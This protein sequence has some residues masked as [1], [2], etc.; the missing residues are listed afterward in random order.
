MEICSYPYN[1]FEEVCSRILKFYFT[2]DAEHGMG[3]L[4]LVS[5]IETVKTKL[6]SNDC[7][8]DSYTEQINAITDVD[9]FIGKVDIRLEEPAEGK[10]IDLII[11]CANCVI[12]IE[13][14]ITAGIY[15]PLEKYCSHLKNKYPGKNI[16]KI[17]LSVK[18]IT[19]PSDYKKINDNGFISILYRSLFKNVKSLSGNYLRQMKY[20]YLLY[21]YDFMKTI[22]NKDNIISKQEREFFYNNSDLIDSIVARRDKYNELVLNEQKEQIAI[23]SEIMGADWKTWEGWILNTSLEE[24][25]KRIGIDSNYE[26]TPDSSCGRFCIY[27]TTWCMEAWWPYKKILTETFPD[28]FIDEY[29]GE[30]KDRVYIHLP[31]ITGN[32]HEEIVKALGNAYNKL[33]EVVD[34]VKHNS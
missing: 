7:T 24:G 3:Y 4:W 16:I 26:A 32:N 31:K 18:P 29:A 12:C 34:I 14:K 17:I 9:F 33:K 13:N 30:K 6:Y 21:M 22:E 15:N 23:L 1:R 27:I 19:S 8:S 5:L 2:P 20:D 28:C 10:K 25:N 11:E